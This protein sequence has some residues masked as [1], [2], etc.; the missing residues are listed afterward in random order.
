VKVFECIVE[1]ERPVRL[2]KYISEIAR[3][4]S[5]SQVKGRFVAASVNGK[6]AKLSR[7]LRS[8]DKV[9]LEYGE[10]EA[11]ELLP[12][13]IP[14][15]VVFEDARVLV[16]DKPQGMVTHPANGNWTGTL[17][18]ALL[19][20]LGGAALRFDG[21]DPRP[22]IV[23]RLDKE[24]SGLIITAKDP[25]AREF[26]ARQFRDRETRKEYLAIV[27]GRPPAA[28]GRIA[29]HLARDPSDRK[30]FRVA[31]AG[32]LAVTDYRLLAAFG[33]YSFVALSPRTGRTHQLRV[34]MRELR[35]P[36][37][38]DPVYSPRDERYPEATLM[39]HAYR[40]EIC[41]PGNGE[42]R[43]FRAPLPER[44]KAVLREIGGGTQ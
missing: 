33:R 10:G 22:G 11:R 37:L 12:Q 17:V 19:H 21:A 13:D 35:C 43:R 2:D 9:R 42:R 27:K 32:K 16:V 39:L 30:K 6:A 29:N 1:A 14:L 20:R 34:H 15:S 5:R 18:N 40:L 31:E 8:G 26:L 36:I 4:M 25:E 7:E 44:F 28:R 23:H 41:L 24:T 38:G 3:L